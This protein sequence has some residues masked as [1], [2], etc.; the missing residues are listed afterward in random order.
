MVTK[1]TFR[2][3]IVMHEGITGSSLK[4]LNDLVI[5]ELISL[6]LTFTFLPK[7]LKSHLKSIPMAL[8]TQTLPPKFLSFFS[9]M[10]YGL[11]LSRRLLHT[12]PLPS[13]FSS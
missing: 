2:P 11:N 10:Q 1:A 12:L 13:P 3:G 5:D 8:E 4:C 7:W 9:Q 6:D